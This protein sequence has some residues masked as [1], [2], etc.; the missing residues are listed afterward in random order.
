[1]C[2]ITISYIELSVLYTKIRL[3]SGTDILRIRPSDTAREELMKA[4]DILTIILVIAA[5]V[6]VIVYA[7]KGRRRN[8]SC[9]FCP[10]AGTCRGHCRQSPFYRPPQTPEEA[11][12]QAKDA[13]PDKLMRH[14]LQNISDMSLRKK[15]D[16]DNQ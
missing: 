10:Y 14:P 12:K 6:V 4:V 11:M 2:N 3:W 13:V 5:V 15:Q 9:G 8:G 1:M 7:E 16:H